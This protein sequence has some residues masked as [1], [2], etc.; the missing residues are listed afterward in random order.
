MTLK[1]VFAPE[2]LAAL[3]Q[4]A[5]ERRRAELEAARASYNDDTPGDVAFDPSAAA[6]GSFLAVFLPNEQASTG[7]VAVVYGLRSDLAG[8]F[9]QGVRAACISRP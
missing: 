8:S 7:G 6:S 1:R 3:K 2:E 9:L 4:R 5:A